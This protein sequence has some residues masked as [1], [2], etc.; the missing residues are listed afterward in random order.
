MSELHLLRVALDTGALVRRGR[1]QGLPLREVDGG[2]LVHAWLL[3]VFGEQRVLSFALDGEIDRRVRV[4][5]YL[6]QPLDALMAEVERF[7]DP[8]DWAAA[9]WSTAASKP[10]PTTFQAGERLGFAVRAVPTRRRSE[11]EGEAERMVE[12]DAFLSAARRDPDGP[13]PDRA[14]VYAAWLGEQLGRDGA[15]TVE[16]STLESFQLSP[17]LRRTQGA[18]RRGRMVTLPDVRLSGVLQVGAPEAFAA[19]LRRGVGR[20]RA[21]GFGMLQLRRPTI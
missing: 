9:D 6:D 12:L 19:L 20:H 16:R 3:A 7:A 18:Q 5:A 21:F 4:F 11:G 17:L 14:A 15:A 2:Y 10:M 8:S 13:K 1:A